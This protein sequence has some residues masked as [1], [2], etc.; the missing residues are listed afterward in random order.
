MI[1][2]SFYFY[3]SDPVL[4]FPCTEGHVTC[5]DCFRQYCSIRLRE[6]QFWQHPEYGYTLACPAGCL[7][8]FIK[9]VHHFHV[10]TEEQVS[11]LEYFL[12]KR[13]QFA[14]F[15]ITNIS[16][17][18]LRNLFLDQG[19]FCVPNRVVAWEFWLSLSVWK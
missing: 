8:S 14:V 6:R 1:C 5:L 7:D 4:V 16:V 13:D 11:Y 17:S 12:Y 9:E 15:S 10:L 2:A 18:E 19:E 3:C